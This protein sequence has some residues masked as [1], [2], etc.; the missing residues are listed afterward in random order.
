MNKKKIIVIFILVIMIAVIYILLK[1]YLP[2]SMMY[3]NITVTEAGGQ[4]EETK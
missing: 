3:D 1:R 4:S 2:Y